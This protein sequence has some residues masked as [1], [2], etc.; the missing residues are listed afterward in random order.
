MVELVLKL[1]LL[2]LLS[3]AV[4]AFGIPGIRGAFYAPTDWVAAQQ[5]IALA[6]IRPGETAI[7]IGS[8]DGRLVI[9]LAQAGAQAR[10]VE[11]NPLLVI[12]SRYRIRKAGLS[13]TATIE[14][15][16]L[17]KTSFADTDIVLL[18]GIPYI[19]RELEKKLRAEMKPGSR[20]VCNHFFFPTWTPE[21][22][23]H[24]IAVYRS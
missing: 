17:W 9:L 8:G 24:G 18:F 19:M 1:I 7:D 23:E 3:I 13:H 22:T 14:W 12:Y 20:V 6:G 11:R 4:F 2:V 16:N 10:G 15:G 21:K 5:M